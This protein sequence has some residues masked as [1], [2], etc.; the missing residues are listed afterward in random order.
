VEQW[1]CAAIAS[2]VIVPP[3][4]PTEV[5]SVDELLEVEPDI[6]LPSQC[7]ANTLLPGQHS[8]TLPASRRITLT[9]ADQ[10][11][12][13][14]PQWLLRGM[15]ERDT[16]ALIF[17]DP[18]CG[19]S[20]L[21]IDWSC[22]LAT[23]TPWRGHDVQK[24]PVVYVAGEGQQGFGRRIRAWSE[25]HGVCLDGVPLYLAPAVGIP[26][27][28]EVIDLITAIDIGVEAVGQ[29]AMIVLDTL[30]RCFGGGD[31]N[32]TQDMSRFVSACDAIRERYKCTILV[33]HHAGH[34]DKT[35]ARGAIALKAALDAEYRLVNDGGLML[36]STKMKDA[37]LPSPL[38]MEMVTVD[39][40]DIT[41]EDGN[42]VTSA[43]IN[44][45]DADISSI[46]AK[47]NTATS[48]KRGKWQQVGMD[49]AHRLVLNA[50]D[51]QASIKEWHQECETAGMPRSTCYDVLAKLQTQGVITVDGEYFELPNH[52][53][54]RPVSSPI[55]PL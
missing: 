2:N 9:R 11:Q 23:G 28:A 17:G 53:S 32:S 35:R 13:R 3:P 31:E 18:G 15:L 29:P 7:Q 27:P 14:P 45:L 22:R 25:Y 43:A 44:I 34:G 8:S 26:N 5:V 21:A 12:M 37:Q 54:D 38:A 46:I 4:K 33:V 39:L 48:G 41:D 51:G 16:F 42:P 55:Q 52:A 1:A 30:A 20:F 6:L 36:T 10:I 24:G 50:D 40:P 47:A 49:M 19:K